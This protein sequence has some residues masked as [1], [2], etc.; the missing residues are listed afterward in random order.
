M[1]KNVIEKKTSLFCPVHYYVYNQFSAA[2]NSNNSALAAGV[3]DSI[4]SHE[5]SLMMFAGASSGPDNEADGPR[6]RPPVSANAAISG[7]S[8]TASSVSYNRQQSE[9]VTH[10]DFGFI[11]NGECSR[12]LYSHIPIFRILLRKLSPK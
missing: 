9:P 1:K 10:D 2:S 7:A 11:A 5:G 3:S 12:S 8:P 4:V 6:P